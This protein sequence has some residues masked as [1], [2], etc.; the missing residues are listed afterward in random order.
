MSQPLTKES[1][2]YIISR[3]GFCGGKPIIEGTKFPVRS[4][5]MYIL[6]LGMTP[7][8]FIQKFNHLTLAQV[9][10]ALSYYYGHREEIEQDL[11]AQSYESARKEFPEFA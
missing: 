8:E 5:V 1:H 6:K 4:V 11:Q 9:H 10:D 7:E 3:P 2:P